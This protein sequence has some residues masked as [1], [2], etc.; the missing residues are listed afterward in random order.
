MPRISRVR[1][2]KV[3][4]RLVELHLRVHGVSLSF[5]KFELYEL[6]SQVRRSSN[7]APA[8]LAEGFNNKHKNIYLESVNRALGEIRETQHHVMVAYKKGIFPR[9]SLTVLS[10]STT[11]P[12][13]CSEPSNALWKRGERQNDP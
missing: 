13:E 11:N 8:N 5:P 2:L 10:V 6:G 7:S 3:Y 4:R 12:A 9:P 1:D